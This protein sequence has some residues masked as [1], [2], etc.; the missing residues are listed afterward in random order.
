[1][2]G[3]KGGSGQGVGGKFGGGLL[4]KKEFTNGKIL[5]GG[6]LKGFQK[7]KKKKKTGK[8]RQGKKGGCQFISERKFTHTEERD[9][10]PRRRAERKP[11]KEVR[12]G[13]VRGSGIGSAPVQQGEPTGRGKASS[14]K[15]P[16]RPQKGKR[17]T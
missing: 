8:G 10:K 14:G 4:F 17:F 1:M 11:G 13:G 15:G 16:G 12:V 5:E 9:G 7:K 6:S 2:A 3:T